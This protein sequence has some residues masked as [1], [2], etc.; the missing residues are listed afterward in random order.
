M[1]DYA[2]SYA[3]GLVKGPGDLC[4]VKHFVTHPSGS[5]FVACVVSAKVLSL[6]TGPGSGPAT[7]PRSG[8]L[9]LRLAWGQKE[10]RVQSRL[11]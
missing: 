3:W 1:K 2:V 11:L 9:I 7:K 5:D 6:N 8:L 10:I 4:N